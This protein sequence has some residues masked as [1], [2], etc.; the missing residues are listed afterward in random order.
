MALVAADDLA[1]GFVQTVMDQVLRSTNNATVRVPY[2][3]GPGIQVDVEA[4]RFRNQNVSCMAPTAG[5]IDLAGQSDEGG[6][7]QKKSVTLD[8]L[9]VAL[10]ADLLVI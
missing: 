3:G 2:C 7:T 6:S 9:S 5:R 8:I 1:G 10:T 4:I